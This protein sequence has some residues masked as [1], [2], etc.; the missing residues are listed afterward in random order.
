MTI[1][2][3]YIIFLITSLLICFG[4]LIYATYFIR[5]GETDKEWDRLINEAIDRGV[6]PKL[7]KTEYYSFSWE[8][9]YTI[10]LGDLRLW[11]ANY[12]YAYARPEK[13]TFSDH[14]TS[15]YTLPSRKTQRR[16]KYYCKAFG[17]N[18]VN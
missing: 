5:L 4:G 13:E 12:P 7:N 17:I 3:V 18:I 16:L 8:D 6:I 2:T 14:S 1:E 10:V 11:N 15:N 9:K